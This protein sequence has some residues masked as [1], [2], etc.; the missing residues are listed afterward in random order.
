MIVGLTS[1]APRCGK[2]T[3]ADFLVQQYGFYKDSFGR[4][5]YLQASAAFGVTVEQLALHEWKTEPQ[6]ELALENC[7][8]ID[9]VAAV[10]KA[11]PPGVDI[12]QEMRAPRTSRFILQQWGTEYR[13]K[14]DEL[15]W[16]ADL[17]E[18]VD[19]IILNSEQSIVISDVREMHEVAYLYELAATSGQKLALIEV[20]RE[21]AMQY[22][23]SHTS[24]AGIPAKYL[25]HRLENIEGDPASMLSGLAQIVHQL[26]SNY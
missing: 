18:R 9:F 12:E 4:G 10:F 19:D 25:S 5:I 16:V 3:C 13:R 2:D 17:K 21:S 7:A 22:K 6:A 24:D 23:S 11:M 1:P 20:S 15:Y 8:D 14:D 26:R